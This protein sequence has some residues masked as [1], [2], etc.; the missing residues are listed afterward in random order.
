MKVKISYSISQ[1]EACVRFIT[2]NNPFYRDAESTV[3]NS[4]QQA[5]RNIATKFPVCVGSGTMGYMV[6]VEEV[7]QED[8]DNDENEIFFTFTV[9][10]GLGSKN[11]ANI[12][13][14]REEII[15]EKE[16]K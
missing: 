13:Y 6:E 16:T 5:I 12:D 4:I 1:Y 15:I 3:R 9:D 10:P 8:L 14:H 7:I 2:E 11:W